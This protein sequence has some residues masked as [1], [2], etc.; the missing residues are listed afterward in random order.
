MLNI[1]QLIH[2]L[3]TYPW[4]KMHWKLP[5]KK[6]ENSLKTKDGGEHCVTSN[7]SKIELMNHKHRTILKDMHTFFFMRN[8]ISQKRHIGVQP[9]YTSRIQT[10]IQRFLFMTLHSLSFPNTYF[11]IY[12]SITLSTSI[13]DFAYNSN[14]QVRVTC[15]YLKV[16]SPIRMTSL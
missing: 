10:P 16:P 13:S 15:F 3:P 2:F 9:Y 14:R 1:V 5:I 8:V 4:Q 11:S 7:R 12:N 6:K